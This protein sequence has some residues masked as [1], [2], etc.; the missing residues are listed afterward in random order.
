[1]KLTVARGSSETITELLLS[2]LKQGQHCNV[3]VGSYSS[4]SGL[5]MFQNAQESESRRYLS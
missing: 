3:R 2:Y 4:C 1:M 5:P